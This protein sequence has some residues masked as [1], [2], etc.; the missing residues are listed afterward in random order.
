MLP[1]YL[2]IQHNILKGQ[3]PA[4]C[5]HTCP[6]PRGPGAPLS[7]LYSLTQ[8]P[9]TWVC[10]TAMEETLRPGPHPCCRAWHAAHRHIFQD[11]QGHGS[12]LVFLM[13]GVG[14]H[15]VNFIEEAQSGPLSG[16]CAARGRRG[17]SG[18]ADSQSRASSQVGGMPPPGQGYKVTLS[19]L[20]PEWQVRSLGNLYQESLQGGP[21]RW[22]GRAVPFSFCQ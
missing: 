12:W 15:G 22:A 16:G 11:L 19:G 3:I 5:L 9:H 6:A 20:F 14:W 2:E 18:F 7:G 10:F 17:G 1:S 8:E 4:G 13:E 21:A